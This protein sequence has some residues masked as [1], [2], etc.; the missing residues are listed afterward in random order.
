MLRPLLLQVCCI[1]DVSLVM[2]I[3][4]SFY[5]LYCHFSILTDCIK[6]LVDVLSTYTTDA[7]IVTLACG[8]LSKLATD[9]RTADRVRDGGAALAVARVAASLH[10]PSSKAGGAA[11]R[12]VARILQR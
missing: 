11:S 8:G 9:P 1:N 6:A 12:L 3:W 2:Y 5:E 7:R 10:E 4:P